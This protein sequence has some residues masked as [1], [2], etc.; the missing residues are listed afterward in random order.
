MQVEYGYGLLERK[1]F[2]LSENKL[3]KSQIR[4]SQTPYIYP[5]FIPEPRT[6]GL[7]RFGSVQFFE[8]PEPNR[9]VEGGTGTEPNRT[10]FEPNRT[11][12]VNLF[13]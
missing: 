12:T 1:Q 7:L 8:G 13:F 4:I 9:I 10:G 11:G 6:L 2:L 5:T 3:L